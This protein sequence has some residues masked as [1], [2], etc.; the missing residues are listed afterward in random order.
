MKQILFLSTATFIFAC[1]SNDRV[2]EAPVARETDERPEFEGHD[3]RPGLEGREGREPIVDGPA[4][5][6]PTLE[7]VEL[8]AGRV[9]GHLT[10]GAAHVCLLHDGGRIMCWG[11]NEAGQLGAS[12]DH[13]RV[14]VSG[15]DDGMGIVAAGDLTCVW[16]RSG[17][18]SCWG[19][20]G[21]STTRG[22]PPTGV[23][24]IDDAVEVAISRWGAQ[25]CVRRTNGNVACWRGW[26]PEGPSPVIGVSNAVD[27]AVDASRA[28]AAISDGTV[29]CW[30]DGGEAS[31]FGVADLSRSPAY[32]SPGITDAVEVAYYDINERSIPS[33]CA[34]TRSGGVR[35]SDNISRLGSG[36]DIM[37][38]IPSPFIAVGGVDNAVALAGWGTSH[39]CALLEDGHLACWGSN[40]ARQLGADTEIRDGLLTPAIH[41][42]VVAE[43]EGVRAVAVGNHF[44][45]A[46]TDEDV[47]C[48]GARDR[49]RGARG[50]HLS[51]IEEID[52]AQELSSS[53]LSHCARRESGRV[54]CWGYVLGGRNQVAFTPLVEVDGGASRLW[55]G[56]HQACVRRADGVSCWGEIVTTEGR[57]SIRSPQLMTDLPANAELE[58]HLGGFCHRDEGGQ[59]V[60]PSR[61]PPSALAARPVVALFLGDGCAA[62][63]AHVD[64]WRRGYRSPGT[65]TLTMPA[66]VTQLTVQSRRACALTGRQVACWDGLSEHPTT[67]RASEGTGSFI[68]IAS[69]DR[70][71]CAITDQRRA[72]CWSGAAA[73]PLGEAEDP[74]GLADLVEIAAADD[75]FCARRAG[76]TVVCWGRYDLR[77]VR[78]YVGP[79]RV[80]ELRVRR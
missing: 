74:T 42:A 58:P 64:C 39:A 12:G 66:P 72:F 41:R 68:Q 33:L 60:C 30:R 15:I 29:R 59:L 77:G 24:G 70:A 23:P 1:G 6:L 25:A 17:R 26:D 8:P 56:A 34:R 35:C 71:V 48:W 49:V 32:R 20:F 80:P 3:E 69:N 45:C 51:R 18:V 46:L 7:V 43:Q 2:Q 31:E 63:G 38:E 11:D 4:R 61:G 40:L 9:N 62:D 54:S 21:E 47:R 22:H 5:D 57:V 50:P 78:P 79:T 28:C 16:R 67:L 27:L 37:R 10:A 52:D 44:S 73:G 14:N 55:V 76:G 19:R 13:S 53:G 36:D 65:S 75:S